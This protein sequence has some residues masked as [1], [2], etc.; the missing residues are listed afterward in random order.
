MTDIIK[1]PQDE[2]I[3]DLSIELSQVSVECAIVLAQTALTEDMKKG[4]K[5]LSPGI[6]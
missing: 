1:L 2:S 3:I 4:M 6:I 5:S